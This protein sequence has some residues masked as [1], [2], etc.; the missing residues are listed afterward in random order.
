M[1]EQILLGLASIIILGIGAEWLAWRFRLPSILLL[2]VFGLIAGPVSGFLN[3]DALFGDL[4][5]PLVSV[6]VAVI[7]FGGG[8][9]LRVSELRQ[10]GS[11][12]RNLV[13]FGALITWLIGAGAAHFLLKLDFA[14]ALLLGAI[15]VVSGPT[16]IIPLLRH[17]RP[18]RQVGSI[19]KWEG[20]V[21]DP[22]GAILAVLVF[23]AIL[24]GGFQ[25]AVTVTA[26]GLLKTIVIGGGFGMLGAMIMVLLLRRFWIP[27]FLHGAVS[28]ALVI[29]VFAAS[30]SL[31]TDSGLLAAAVMGIAMANQKTV[32]VRHIVQFKEDLGVLLV[33][34]LFILLAARVQLSD[35]GHIGM[36]SLAFLGVLMLV[37]RPAS[38]ALSTL[39][40]RLS[41][42]ERL[43]L[44]WMAPRGI[45]AAAIS[46]IFALR[47][48]DVG[49]PKAELLVP[50]TFMVIMSTVT[51]YGLT[52]S[53][54][55]RRLKVA[56]PN[57]QGVLV[58]G[59]H[60]WS[61]AIASALQAEGYSV[62]VV[63]DSWANISAA[64]MA[65]LPT[66][67]ASILSQ[68]ALDEIELGG[69]GR[70][71]AL[72]SDDEYNSLAALQ[73]IDVFGRA[74]VYQLPPRGEEKGPRETVSRHLQG[75]LLFGEGIGYTYLA[76]RFAR[77]AVIKTTKLTQE[78]DYDAFRKLYGEE[79]IPLFTIAQNGNL[80][81]F[82]KDS[83]PTPRPGHT[84]I[85]LV[86]SVDEVR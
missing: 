19:L 30:N 66:F 56:S 3:P 7:L 1:T 46:S 16:V 39:R 15:L 82:T 67:Y 38:V 68:Y 21:I 51:I 6:A 27:D 42:S 59:A 9:N 28:L 86:D 25:E 54:L 73:F 35:L 79:A 74:E 17:L 52:A 55:A 53:P 34:G 65:G 62:L 36:G 72:T 47:L 60:S 77:G 83:P 81:V 20:I 29:G 11:V 12:V 80:V 69:I 44:S 33:S 24:A 85:S 37:A 10:I 4:L 18:S 32:S 31:Q 22:I 58:V 50:I 8:L 45:V 5:L 49:Y 23:E 61:R 40:S 64:R 71:L 2:L 13:T 14:L 63:D 84:L 75:R 76:S 70:L 78:F 41:R 57:P 43:F 48:V 26:V